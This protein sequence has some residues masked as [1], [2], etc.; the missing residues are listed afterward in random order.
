[1]SGHKLVKDNDDY[2]F[3]SNGYI[4]DK[5]VI[6]RMFERGFFAGQKDGLFGESQTYDLSQELLNHILNINL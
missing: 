1:L 3:L 4:P 5:D 2:W 6:E